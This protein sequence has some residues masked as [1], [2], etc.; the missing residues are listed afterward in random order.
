[1]D[2]VCNDSTLFLDGVHQKN[3]YFEETH[4]DPEHTICVAIQS[5]S[6]CPQKSI[7]TSNEN[8]FLLLKCEKIISELQLITEDASEENEVWNNFC[9]KID[10]K[11]F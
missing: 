9:Q 11:P 5:S 3:W 8:N 2:N 7:T 6:Q 4:I 1:M 10:K